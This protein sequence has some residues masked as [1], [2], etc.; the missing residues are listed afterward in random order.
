MPDPARSVRVQ[1]PP[2]QDGPWER[3][4]W[5]VL[6]AH[7][8]AAPAFGSEPAPD[9]VV[10]L[11]AQDGATLT[12]RTPAAP[13]PAG[14]WRRVRI[15]TPVRAYDLL[16]GAGGCTLSGTPG[17]WT[18]DGDLAGP[19]IGLLRLQEDRD[20]PYRDRYGLVC[21][22]DSPRCGPGLLSEPVLENAA[23]A[24]GDLLGLEV[25]ARFGGRARWALAVSCDVDSVETDH[26]G[27]VLAV[28]ARH[29]VERPTFMVCA[30]SDADKTVRDPRYD[31]ADAEIR[32]R[33]A[34]LERADVEIGLHGSYL[35]HDRVA[36][37]RA[38][39]DRLE[40]V[41]GRAVPGHRSHYYRFA[42][43]RSW[44]WQHRAG[45]AYDAS[46]GYPDLPGLRMG[47]TG[48]VQFLDPQRGPV[49]FALCPT[50][51]LDQ[52][53]FWPRPWADEEVDAYLDSLT[54]KTASAGGVLVVDWH[55]YTLGSA[56]PGW[57]RPLERL[58]SLARGRG[59][60]VSGIAEA[61]RYHGF[62]L[63]ETASADPESD[64]HESV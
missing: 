29:K 4:L 50:A 22:R 33:L 51:I 6:L 58:L 63:T 45:F 13:E 60:Y 64:P 2:G 30:A 40:Q 37:L 57:W 12:L 56:Y 5:R 16:A 28:L 25:P 15:E 43:P 52:H 59:A 47:C 44:A 19:L 54:T 20:V 8:G 14:Q 10:R 21:G 7:L 62:G 32:R 38:Q 27:D 31:L 24:I 61:L 55:T 35:A 23:A 1:C 9:G 46:L 39:K 18:L 36:M 11:S 48:P 41:F 17:A 26:I 49:G 3:H 53:F 34:P 42:Y